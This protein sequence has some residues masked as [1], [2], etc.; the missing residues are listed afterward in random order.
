VALR[1]G[2]TITRKVGDLMKANPYNDKNV[3]AGAL[4]IAFE[5]ERRAKP[6]APVD[7]GRLRGSI[8]AGEDREGAFVKTNVEYAAF[9]EFGTMQ[10][11]QRTDPGPTPPWYRHSAEPGGVPAQPFLRPAFHEVTGKAADIM[12]RVV[13]KK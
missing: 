8:E 11:G 9:Q 10:T 5:M 6:K 12:R 13:S 3:R 1:L 2:A 4:E 7:E